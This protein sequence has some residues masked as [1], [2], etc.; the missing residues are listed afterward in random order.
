MSLLRIIERLSC[1]VKETKHFISAG[2]GKNCD[3]LGYY[4]MRLR[5]QKYFWYTQRNFHGRYPERGKHGRFY[6]TANV[7]DGYLNPSLTLSVLFCVSPN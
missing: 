5:G 4:L 6:R 3:E 7:S 1:R 2:K